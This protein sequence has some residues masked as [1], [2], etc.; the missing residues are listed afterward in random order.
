MR[1]T[2]VISD[3]V[4]ERARNVARE[5]G[6]RLSVLVTEATEEF[7]LRM[8]SRGGAHK[9]SAVRLKPFSMGVPQ[10]D[11]DNREELYR[12]MEEA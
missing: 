7:L 3:P 5:K 6:M 11:I 10:A 12:K 8:E 1:T 9:R 4:Y 2:L